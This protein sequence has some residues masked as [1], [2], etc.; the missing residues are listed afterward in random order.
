MPVYG[1]KLLGD[2]ATEE[3]VTSYEILHSDNG[4]TFSASSNVD[5]TA[6]V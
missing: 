5:G 2:R 3:Y 6:K 1:I 4:V